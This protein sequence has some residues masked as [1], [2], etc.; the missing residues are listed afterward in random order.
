MTEA[1]HSVLNR[2][3][4]PA[5]VLDACV[6]MSG[7]LRPLLLNLAKT[8]LFDPLWTDKIGQEWQR[9]A[10]RLWPIDPELLKSEWQSMQEQFPGANMGDVTPFEASLKHTDRKDKHVAATGIASVAAGHSGPIS[11]L[12]WNIKDF[13]RSEL[14]RQQLGLIDPDRLFS[15]WWPTHRQILSEVLDL[16]V[17]ELVSSGRRQPEPML[18]MLRRDR[19]FRLAG[20]YELAQK[21]PAGL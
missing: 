3:E 7:L 11:V 5:L 12:T 8:D 19:L 6:M 20:L 21:N 14:R 2:S 15:Q 16:T 9:N 18:G 4:R 1:Q 17:A 13:S 10:A